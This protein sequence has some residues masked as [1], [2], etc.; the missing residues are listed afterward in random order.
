MGIIIEYCGDEYVLKLHQQDDIRFAFQK[1]NVVRV[2]LRQ[3][4][5]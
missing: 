4:Q 5:N 3:N 1:V 2:G